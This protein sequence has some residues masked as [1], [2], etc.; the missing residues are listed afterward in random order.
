MCRMGFCGG[1]GDGDGD[2]GGGG[3]R[4]GVLI[5]AWEGATCLV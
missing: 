1:D 5:L 3:G 2:G 4:S